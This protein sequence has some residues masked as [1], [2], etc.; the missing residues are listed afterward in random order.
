MLKAMISSHV[1]LITAAIIRGRQVKP[2]SSLSVA[3]YL[4]YSV[5]F[6]YELYCVK[7]QYSL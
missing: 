6:D 4:V 3:I 5:L 2:P 7:S 1:I